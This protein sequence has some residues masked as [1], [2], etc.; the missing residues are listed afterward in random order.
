MNWKDVIHKKGSISTRIKKENWEDNMT[1]NNYFIKQVITT[2]KSLNVLWKIQF[3]SLVGK[4]SVFNSL[5]E[6][7]DFST[8]TRNNKKIKNKHLTPEKFS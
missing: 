3:L 4:N 8:H 5:A 6:N 7:L 1:W 2:Y